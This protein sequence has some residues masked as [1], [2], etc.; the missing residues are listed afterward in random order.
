MHFKLIPA[1]RIN[2]EIFGLLVFARALALL[3][4][5]TGRLASH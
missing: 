1:I 4:L 3:P 5:A 2:G